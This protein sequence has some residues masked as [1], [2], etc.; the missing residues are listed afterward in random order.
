MI[1]IPREPG[2]DVVKAYGVDIAAFCN[3]VV[4]IYAISNGEEPA[5]RVACLYSVMDELIGL[6]PDLELKFQDRVGD[7]ELYL[8]FKR[9]SFLKRIFGL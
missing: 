9:K 4:R 1:I 5:T 8:T 3:G 6:N 2:Y 7:M